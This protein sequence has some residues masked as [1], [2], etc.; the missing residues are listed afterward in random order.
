MN[1]GLRTLRKI[2]V[3]TIILL[4]AGLTLTGCRKRNAAMERQPA[5]VTISEAVAKDVPAYIDEI[6]TCAASEAVSI[7]PQASGQI[8]E[9]HFADG[10]DLKKGDMLFVID[11][12][13]YQA[14]LEQA[15]ANL[16]QSIASLDLAKSAFERAKE[17]LP[18]GALSQEGYD[19][20]QSAVAIGQAQVQAAQAA[21]QTAQV[22]LDYCFIHSPIDG[23]AGQ[24]QAD[25]GNVVTANSD[26]VLLVIQRLDPIYA[27]FTIT[28]QD[29]D[30][31]RREM[32]KGELK[33][34]VRLPDESDANS[35]EGTLT[36]LNNAV[37]K[38]TGTVKLRAALSNP[39][40][41]FWPGQFV[42]VRLVLSTLKDAVLVPSEAIQISQNG[43]FVYVF[44]PDSNAELRLVKPGQQQG[45]LV[46]ITDGIK[47]GE[48]VV[49]GGQ[50]T[51]TPGGK[52][53]LQEMM[54]QGGQPP[55]S[56][57]AQSRQ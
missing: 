11:P 43:P 34:Y 35:R 22:N 9:I 18:T 39:D 57:G 29:L 42:K 37:Q 47:A 7:R 8:T 48:K 21:V 28:E 19:I 45:K 14:S 30:S 25:I 13:P 23:R 3:L 31:V 56:Q 38:E 32:A 2:A 55:Q 33:T 51:V 44:T 16:A 50:L 15:K 10:A 36:F 54:P 41:Y 12:K 5:L 6:G 27:D 20:R 17:L 46:V 24:H 1:T 52:V 4:L 40:R 26:I 53:R 49:T